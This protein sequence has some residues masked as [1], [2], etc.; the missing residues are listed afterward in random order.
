MLAPFF[1]PLNLVLYSKLV[2]GYRFTGMLKYDTVM[3]QDD[4]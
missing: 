3:C 1:P 2:G 4:H